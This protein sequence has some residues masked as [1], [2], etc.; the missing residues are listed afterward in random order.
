MADLPEPRPYYIATPMKSGKLAWVTILPDD[1]E[2]LTFLDVEKR[3]AV[4]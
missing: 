4:S 3:T 1:N 2:L